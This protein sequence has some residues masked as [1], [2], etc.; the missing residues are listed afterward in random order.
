LKIYFTQ[1]Y[2]KFIK[3]AQL[4][5]NKGGIATLGS[6]S[7]IDDFINLSPENKDILIKKIGES[8]RDEFSAF[9]NA[10]V[11][12][13]FTKDLEDS[14]NKK[15]REFL[16]NDANLQ[17]IPEAQL[18]DALNKGLK[19][20]QRVKALESLVSAPIEKKKVALSWAI[21]ELPLSELAQVAQTLIKNDDQAKGAFMK[22]LIAKSKDKLIEVIK[23]SPDFGLLP[24]D[25]VDLTFKANIDMALPLL[26]VYMLDTNVGDK[27]SLAD[28]IQPVA[29][30][31]K[32]RLAYTD[33]EWKKFLTKKY[34]IYKSI[35]KIAIG[36]IF[37]SKGPQYSLDN[38]TFRRE[39]M[40][41]LH[42]SKN[43]F[44]DEDKK[45]LEEYIKAPPSSDFDLKTFIFLDDVGANKML[46]YIEDQ[47]LTDK[48]LNTEIGRRYKKK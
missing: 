20:E 16:A 13:K 5:L 15:R 46:K 45:E 41:A 2:S 34:E 22:L 4:L 31:I 33:E 23:S 26:W 11:R 38:A 35:N 3:I 47:G 27:Q 21:D 37:S 44:T 42:A 9:S 14:V 10:L 48:F 36:N 19:P 29:S 12:S 24:K 25:L 28:I 18:L 30:A 6:S 1:E 40:S 43:D 8:N 17:D 7:E 39:I 32:A